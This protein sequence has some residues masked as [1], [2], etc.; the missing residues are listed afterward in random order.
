VE[1]EAATKPAERYLRAVLPDSSGRRNDFPADQGYRDGTL[2]VLRRRAE[3]ALEEF[4]SRGVVQQRDQILLLSL[5]AGQVQA[6][7]ERNTDD[8]CEE[9]A[10]LHVLDAQRRHCLH[11]AIE[12]AVVDV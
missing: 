8:V 2:R 1:G 4:L 5:I 11:D 3:K 7:P 10:V 12:D 6:L 9:V